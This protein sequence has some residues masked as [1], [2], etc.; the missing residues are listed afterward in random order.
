MYIMLLVKYFDWWDPTRQIIFS[1]KP[2]IPT[3]AFHQESPEG[4]KLQKKIQINNQT[5]AIFI[6]ILWL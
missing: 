3:L 2:M 4:Q 5:W 1:H 6:A